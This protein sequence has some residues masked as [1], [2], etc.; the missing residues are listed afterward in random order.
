MTPRRLAASAVVSGVLVL[1]AAWHFDMSVESAAVAA[2]IIVLSVGAAAFLVVLWAKIIR[3]SF[4]R[5]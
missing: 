2:P 4:R 1:L 3:E 5:R